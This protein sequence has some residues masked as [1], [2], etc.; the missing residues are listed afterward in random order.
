MTAFVV[1]TLLGLGIATFLDMKEKE[2]FL[3]WSHD[4]SEWK[5]TYAD[6][7]C[8]LERQRR[9]CKNCKKSQLRI[10]TA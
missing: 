5:I 9:E 10:V 2:C 6:P 3:P 4:W 8:D 7:L 1:G